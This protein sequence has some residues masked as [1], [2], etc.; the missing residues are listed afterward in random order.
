MPLTEEPTL[1]TWK[2]KADLEQDGIVEATF[3]VSESVLPKFE[4]TIEGM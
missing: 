4:V 3:T 1:G 2:I